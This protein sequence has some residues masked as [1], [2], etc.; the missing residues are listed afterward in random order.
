MS[1]KIDVLPNSSPASRSFSGFLRRHS[2]ACGILLMF[3]VTWT[4]DL[5]ASG[6]LPFEVPIAALLLTG[7]GFVFSSILMTWLTLGR[8]AVLTLLKRFLIWRLGVKWYLVALLLLPGLQLASIFLT[9]VFT[10]EP[11][12]FRSAWAYGFFG[13]SARL[14]LFFLPWFLYEIFTN[15]EEIG[16]RGYILPRLQYRYNALFASLVVGLLW[17]F[18]HL[19]KFLGTGSNSQRSF[20]WFLI[21][22]LALAVLYTWL[23]NNSNGSLL[24]VTIFHA[25]GNT[26]GSFLPISFAAPGGI[27][28]NLMILLYLLAAVFVAIIAGPRSLSSTRPKQ[29]QE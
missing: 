16:W 5:S 6:V 14:S 21:A 23:Y 1:N 17:A 27:A 8:G 28:S 9:Q 2:L 22:H 26:A 24:L 15:G 10:G 19:P 4:M 18:W 13:S 29:V 20:A 11:V 12:D 7:W 3:L 25:S